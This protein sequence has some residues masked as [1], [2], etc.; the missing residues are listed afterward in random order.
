MAESKINCKH[1]KEVACPSLD[2]N[3]LC[4]DDCINFISKDGIIYEVVTEKIDNKEQ[5]FE[6][7]SK[8]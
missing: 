8:K 3:R 4:P 6:K 2:E 7:R 1:I 5:V